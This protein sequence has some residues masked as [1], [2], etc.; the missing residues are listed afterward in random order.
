MSFP[1]RKDTSTFWTSKQT[2]TGEFSIADSSSI[3][4]FQRGLDLPSARADFF[5]DAVNQFGSTQSAPGKG[6]RPIHAF[7][8]AH[9]FSD[10]I[11]DVRFVGWFSHYFYFAF[12]DGAVGIGALSDC[13]GAAA[14]TGHIIRRPW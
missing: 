1:S 11:A 14:S 8:F 3:D 10:E 12:L 6:P 9:G 2:R 13:A 4:A 5:G 7:P